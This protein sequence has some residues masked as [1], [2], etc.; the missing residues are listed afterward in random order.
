V[1]V[2]SHSRI[3]TYETCPLQFKFQYI[4][5]IKVEEA[6]TIE[7]FLGSCVHDVLEKLYRDLR[8]EKRLSLE[9]LLEAFDEIWKKNW[10]ESIRIVKEEYTPENYRKMGERYIRDYYEKHRPFDRG[11]I[12]GLETQ[13]TLTLDKE[14][15]Y[16]FHIRIDRL[17]DMGDG[18]YEVHDYKTNFALPRQEALDE[19]RQLAMYSLWVREQ[20][21]D[22]K[23]ARLVW[24]YLAHNK[25]MDSFRTDEQLEA[26][27]LDVLSKIRQIESTQDFTPHVSLMCDWCLY[28]NLC[29]EWKHEAQL[30]AKVEN[31][32]LA[33][34]G[35]KLVDEY[36]RIKSDLDGYKSHAEERLLKLKEAIV[37][38]CRK[39]N[40]SVV[41]GSEK[42]ISVKEY[43]TIKLPSRYTTGREQLVLVLKDLGRLDE[44]TDIDMYALAR[45]MK[46]GRLT[47]EEMDRLDPCVSREKAFRLSVS[48]RK[49]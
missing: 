18:F 34:P 24:H 7:A 26:L 16:K 11:R 37:R 22:F 33:D 45:L 28:K 46:A 23:K 38:F 10:D 8:Y 47:R 41:F 19:D 15:R 12:I 4:D 5:R 25:E 30:D 21:K 6:N 2:Y 9:E 43:E 20:F 17:M 42:K 13:D 29:P 39:E 49:Q 48:K 40:V 36:V 3:G 27:R 32:Y 35:L 44:V 14:G 31:E 1:P